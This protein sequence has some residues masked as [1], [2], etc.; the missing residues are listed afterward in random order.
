MD[1][2]KFSLSVAS[3]SVDFKN[4][5]TFLAVAR[6]SSFRAAAERLAATQPEIG[7][8]HV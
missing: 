8:A 2:D 3:V 1:C 5:E 4:L 7:R 6:L